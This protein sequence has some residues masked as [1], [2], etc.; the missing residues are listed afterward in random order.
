MLNLIAKWLKLAILSLIK[1]YQ[2][3]L[4]PDQGWFRA[5][6]PNGFCPYSPH[7]SDYCYQAIEK[8][9]IV[10]GVYRGLRRVLRCHPWSKGGLDPV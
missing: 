6:Y 2:K 1:L 9:G 3:T 4:S 5:L 10:M 8:Y 7:C